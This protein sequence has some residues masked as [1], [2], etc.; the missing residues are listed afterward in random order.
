MLPITL[1]L[2]HTDQSRL[3]IPTGGWLQLLCEKSYCYN[4]TVFRFYIGAN[5]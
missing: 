2:N 3:K 4:Y 5:S 1:K